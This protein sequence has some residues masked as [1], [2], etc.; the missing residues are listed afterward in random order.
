MV[1]LSANHPKSFLGFLRQFGFIFLPLAV[2]PPGPR[3][4]KN[5]AMEPRQVAKSTLAHCEYSSALMTGFR[6][7]NGPDFFFHLALPCPFIPRFGQW[8]LAQ[9]EGILLQSETR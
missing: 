8:K 9:R 5:A 4:A 6:V 7:E 2:K 3:P 1:R